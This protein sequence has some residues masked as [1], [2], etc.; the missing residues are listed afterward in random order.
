LT[1]QSGRLAD[2]IQ[3]LDACIQATPGGLPEDIFL[4]VSRVTPLVN[5]DLLIQDDD[6]RTLLT[7][8]H[9]EFYGPGWHVP[10]GIIRF[11]EH[12][13]ARIR[14]VA[15][16]E[17]GATVSFVTAPIRVLESIAPAKQSR[18]HFISLL[19]PCRLTSGLDLRR[20]HVDGVPLPGQWQWH[21]SCPG[22]LI[23]EQRP[24]AALMG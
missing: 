3:Q 1:S 24:Y 9:D 11:Q 7:W 2:S 10:G 17:L 23:P 13:D 4:F 21:N 14:V 22:N 8:R 20:Q 5:V 16:E 15:S 12:A 19:Y 6:R 18:G